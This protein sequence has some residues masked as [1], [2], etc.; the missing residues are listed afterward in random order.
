M[1][2]D[3]ENDLTNT[4]TKRPNVPPLQSA[5]TEFKPMNLPDFQSEITLPDDVSSEDLIS[6]FTTYY[7]LEIIDQIVYY[8]NNHT[9][10]S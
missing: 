8:T 3:I 7:T 9:R 10:T 6:L 1:R 4:A 5:S 2:E